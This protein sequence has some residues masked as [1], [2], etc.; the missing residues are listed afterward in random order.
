MSSNTATCYANLKN[1]D[2]AIDACRSALSIGPDVD[3]I[4][5]RGTVYFAAGRPA[6]ARADFE[7]AAHLHDSTNPFS[8]T[9]VRLGDLLCDIDRPSS[10]ARASC[11][12]RA[13][14]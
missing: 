6:E 13:A 8:P 11:V 9:F 1:F 5:H 7:S 2:L 14:T 12:R 3:S 4:A 10:T